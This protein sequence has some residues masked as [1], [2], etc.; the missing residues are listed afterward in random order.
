M[1]ITESVVAILLISG[2]SAVAAFAT[3]PATPPNILLIV[4]DDQGYRDLGCYGSQDVQTPILD[5]LAAEGVRLTNFYVSCPACTP[6]R[7]SLLTGRYP[8]RHGTTA[9]FR[10]DAVDLG[11]QYDAI[12]YAVSPERILGMDER[13]VMVAEVLRKAGY[14]TGLY[15]KWDL[16][17][18]RRFLPRQRGF[19]EF[20]GFVNTGIDYYTHERYGVPSMYRNN[21]P[22]TEGKGTYA[23]HLFERE[24]ARFLE[25]HHDRPFF[26]YV[27]FNAPHMP[28]S[29]D[30][31]VR[32]RVQ[33]PP[34]YLERYPQANGDRAERR[35]AYMAAVTCMD[36]A[37]G[38]LLALLD[39]HKLSDRTL[40][41]FLSD[42]GAS[43]GG[44]NGPLRGG[45]A[46]LFEGGIRV[47]CIVRW[48][49]RLPR[50]RVCDGFLSAME[51]F[52]TLLA[53]SGAPVPPGIVLDGFDMLP[54]LAGAAASP[55][56]EM[57]WEFRGQAAARVGPWKWVSSPKGGGLFN[58]TDD[59]GEKHDLS[60]D[61]PQALDRVTAR[62]THWR[63]Q[64]EA[65]E[66]RGPFRDY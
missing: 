22:T 65:A 31:A 61:R 21:D 34:E 17:Q 26:L 59:P 66:P 8:Q 30:A 28:S 13:E 49:G 48:P 39:E 33:V 7:A 57:F 18:L 24:A 37:I 29:L 47:P 16:G 27:A 58:L 44:D 5:G 64:M 54:V 11:L 42:N 56:E 25:R 6:S 9:L 4:S 35:R 46:T 51:V 55:R 15:G 40:V 19:D 3:E 10:N 2:L 60:A 36:E 14:A 52:P 1:R 53:A 62:L 43:G 45:K 41:V 20:F 38:R 12:R 63:Q 32:S 50:G 23:T